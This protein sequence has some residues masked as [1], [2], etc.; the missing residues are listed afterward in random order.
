ME[1]TVVY[2]QCNDICQLLITF[3][4]WIKGLNK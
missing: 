4:I 2:T 1:T 3:F